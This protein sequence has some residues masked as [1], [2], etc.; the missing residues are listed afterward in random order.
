MM[1]DDIE[2]ELPDGTTV[3]GAEIR[4]IIPPGPVG[5]AVEEALRACNLAER[6]VGLFLSTVG[7]PEEMAEALRHRYGNGHVR[8]SFGISS[9]P[10]DR[11][12]LRIDWLKAQGDPCRTTN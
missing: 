10:Q 8:V 3:K 7:L 12:F 6:I 1:I 4:I 9:D 5:A 11:T 2:I